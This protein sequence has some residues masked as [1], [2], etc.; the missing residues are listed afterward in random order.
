MRGGD[1]YAGYSL[2]NNSMDVETY[3]FCNKSYFF[4]KKVPPFWF[5]Q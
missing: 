4:S 1:A 2:G 5:Q 3:Y